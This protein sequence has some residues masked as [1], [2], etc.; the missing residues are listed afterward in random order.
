MSE[1]RPF[2]RMTWR[3]AAVSGVIWALL[4][5]T[6]KRIDTGALA[7]ELIIRFAIY[8]SLW[9]VVFKL[10]FDATARWMHSR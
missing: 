8:F 4:M 5:C 3:T 9:T 10:L 7:G 1:P 6:W 2:R